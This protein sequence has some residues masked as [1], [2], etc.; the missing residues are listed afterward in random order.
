MANFWWGIGAVVLLVFVIAMALVIG[1]EL[2][3][4]GVMMIRWQ[5]CRP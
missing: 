4:S 3:N 1:G 5:Q 2:R